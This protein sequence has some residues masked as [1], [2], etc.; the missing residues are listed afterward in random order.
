[1]NKRP[2]ERHLAKT[3]REILPRRKSLSFSEINK[4]ENLQTRVE[5]LIQFI[6]KK[7]T[8]LR[9]I[10]V[11]QALN[12]DEADKTRICT[13]VLYNPRITAIKF[14]SV[15]LDHQLSRWIAR[16]RRMENLEKLEFEGFVSIPDDRD[17]RDIAYMLQTNSTLQELSLWALYSDT[18]KLFLEAIAQFSKP[19]ASLKKLSIKWCYSTHACFL[20]VGQALENYTSLETLD[21]MER[22]NSLCC[23]AANRIAK[24]IENS[25]SLKAV[26]IDVR[27]LPSAGAERILHALATK[28]TLKTVCISFIPRNETCLSAAAR[29]MEANKSIERIYI[30]MIHR[31]SQDTPSTDITAL[32]RA[33]ASN[34]SLKVLAL[35]DFDIDINGIRILR[36]TLHNNDTL[37]SLSL[38]GNTVDVEGMRVICDLILRS[39]SL[40][41]LDLSRNGFDSSAIDLLCEAMQ[42]SSSI[43]ELNLFGNDMTGEDV[44]QMGKMLLRNTSLK[45]L[46][47]WRVQ[48]LS[49]HHVR[50]LVEG[51]KMH[52]AI[53]KAQI[54]L[55]HMSAGDP[56]VLQQA[57]DFYLELNRGPRR[58]LHEDTTL[59][60]SLWPHILKR[61]DDYGRMNRRPPSMLYF[62]VREKCD[63]FAITY[64]R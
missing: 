8:D 41:N 11:D 32:G 49:E 34:N 37:E 61:A 46:C 5:D 14:A 20:A 36:D 16:F 45:T 31:R 51:V 30:K 53:T 40:K 21:V 33:L 63:L 52:P 7:N 56:A 28:S 50:A 55:T 44:A 4:I 64:N 22:K 54:F 39:N 42:S 6:D 15:S 24:G 57:L 3:S 47:L 25:P 35:T 58:L 59:P 26:N 19:H 23:L 38:S 18:T 1:M 13:A 12:M 48:N 2:T 62:F 17:A 43:K 9:E 27:R 29:M 10:I 60:M